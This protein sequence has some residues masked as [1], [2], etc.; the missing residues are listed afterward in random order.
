[1]KVTGKKRKPEFKARVALGVLRGDRA[2]RETVP[3]WRFRRALPRRVSNTLDG[4]FC[5]A[6]LRG[7]LARHGRPG[8]FNTG[9]GARSAPNIEIKCKVPGQGGPTQSDCLGGQG[10]ALTPAGQFW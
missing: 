9:Q 4:E 7:A 8:I 5:A 10:A 6:A 1:M 3:N 2:S